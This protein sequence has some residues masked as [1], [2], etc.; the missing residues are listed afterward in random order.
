VTGETR[1]DQREHR[2]VKFSDDLGLP[3]VDGVEQFLDGPLGVAWQAIAAFVP[4][5]ISRAF[6][7][8]SPERIAGL[9][10]TARAWSGEDVPNL[11][12]YFTVECPDF[13]VAYAS[14]SDTRTIRRAWL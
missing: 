2:C 3:Y 7:A 4:V 14:V 12:S 8:D 5:T 1:A 13:A 10:D 6:T 11:L 9:L